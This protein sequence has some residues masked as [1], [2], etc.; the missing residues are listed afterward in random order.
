[1]DKKKENN[2]DLEKKAS[3]TL[4]Q[5]TRKARRRTLAALGT[6][7]VAALAK[8]NDTWV[9]PVV[10]SVILPSHAQTSL[11]TFACQVRIEEV[12]V[13][14]SADISFP[15]VYNQPGDYTVDGW[16][17][18]APNSIDD[19]AHTFSAQIIP[20]A[21]V[22]ISMSYS[23]GPNDV[24]S[25]ADNYPSDQTVVADP[26]TGVAFFQG[27]QYDSVGDDDVNIV[28]TFAAAGFP[29]RTIRMNFNG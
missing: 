6:G 14:G 13:S 21:A 3:E 25:E 20:P 1:M 26:T 15:I 27:L 28:L 7:G 4:E 24:S 19:P 18:G 9:K 17:D 5:D 2:Q 22:P 8:S 16:T 23:I 29:D 11:A 10:D 12:D